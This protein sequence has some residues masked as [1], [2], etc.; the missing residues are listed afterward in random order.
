[1]IC[2]VTDRR[3]L[4]AGPD[5]AG[6]LVHLVAAAARAGVDL[7]QVRERDL[8]ARDLQDLVRRC[9]RSV[10]GTA[11]RVVVNDRVDVAV[12]AGAHGVHL[13]SDSMPA[14]AVRSLLPEGAIVGRSVHRAG[15]ASAVSREGA[16]DYLVFG[17]LFETASKPAEH[18][19]GTLDDLA[20]A[21]RA[22]EQGATGRV[23]VLAIGGMT[24]ERAAL[25]ARAGAAGLAAIGL[26][27]PPAGDDVEQYVHTIVARVRQTFDTCAAVP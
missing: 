5:A 8:G 20:A 17:T 13:R 21:C 23:P 25:A 3:R 19:L 11:A 26:F 18:P 14:P 15:E 16:V 4:P 1:M 27:I 10:E 24:V 6:R 2:L 9:V 22:G 7:I 12:A